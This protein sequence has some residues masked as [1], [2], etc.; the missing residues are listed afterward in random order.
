MNC[1]ANMGVKW[2]EQG[3][4]DNPPVA[5]TST[6]PWSNKSLTDT[7]LPLVKKEKKNKDFRGFR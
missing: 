2:L 6:S 7:K 1:M 3:A 5:L 4:L